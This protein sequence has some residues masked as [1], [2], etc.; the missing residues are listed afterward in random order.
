MS[1]IVCVLPSSYGDTN[2]ELVLFYKKIDTSS[3]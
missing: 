1:H 3:K 2:Q